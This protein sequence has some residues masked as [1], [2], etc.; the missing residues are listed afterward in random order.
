MD[1]D[2]RK[3]QENCRAALLGYLRQLAHAEQW[4]RTNLLRPDYNADL[5]LVLLRGILK[6]EEAALFNL[7]ALGGMAA[8]W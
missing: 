8:T 5:R 6:T 4:L 2:Q 1:Y 3:H 7:Y